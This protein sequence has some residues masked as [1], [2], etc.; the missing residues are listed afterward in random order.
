[1][2]VAH[3]CDAWLGNDLKAHSDDDQSAAGSFLLFELSIQCNALQWWLSILEIQVSSRL[4]RKS[5][6]MVSACKLHSM[7]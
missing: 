7:Q 3:N 5:C 1:M 4:P 2:K 6:I